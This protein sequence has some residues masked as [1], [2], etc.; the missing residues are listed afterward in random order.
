MAGTIPTQQLYCTTSGAGFASYTLE[1]FYYVK[2]YRYRN[3]ECS[4]RPLAH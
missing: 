1:V 4:Q 3:L 2:T